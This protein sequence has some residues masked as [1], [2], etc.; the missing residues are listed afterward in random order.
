M[1]K[2]PNIVLIMAD[3]LS[4]LFMGTY[5]HPLVRTPSIDAVAE[6]GV[7]FDNAYTNSP[8]CALRPDSRSWPAS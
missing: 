7:R 5:G 2:A 4:P 6:R 1:A 8:L 3:Q